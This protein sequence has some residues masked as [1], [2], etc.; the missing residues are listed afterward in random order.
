MHSVKVLKAYSLSSSVGKEGNRKWWALQPRGLRGWQQ[1]SGP[2]SQALFQG[3]VQKFTRSD[4]ADTTTDYECQENLPSDKCAPL[5]LSVLVENPLYTCHR[6][7]KSVS[8]ENG[9]MSTVKG[10]P[11]GTGS[12]RGSFLIFLLLWDQL[13]QTGIRPPWH[14]GQASA[15]LTLSSASHHEHRAWELQALCFMPSCIF[16]SDN[17]TKGDDHSSHGSTWL[18]ATALGTPLRLPALLLPCHPAPL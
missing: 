13:A 11:P 12:G 5:N 17:L 2:G 1:D 8:Q 15:S 4:R 16:G 9:D 3:A 6:G 18:A 14:T 10:R 7:V